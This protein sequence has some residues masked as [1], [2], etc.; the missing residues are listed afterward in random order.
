MLPR[1][2]SKQRLRLHFFVGSVFIMSVMLR[3]L[4]QSYSRVVVRRTEDVHFRERTV[5]FVAMAP[6]DIKTGITFKERTSLDTTSNTDIGHLAP[7]PPLRQQDEFVTGLFNEE[8]GNDVLSSAAKSIPAHEHADS[9]KELVFGADAAD[10]KTTSTLPPSFQEERLLG[11]SVVILANSVTKNTDQWEQYYNLYLKQFKQSPIYLDGEA[12]DNL[13]ARLRPSGQLE[14]VSNVPLVS[15]IMTTWN[16]ETS[17]YAAAMSI[18]QQTWSSIEL[19]I[20]DDASTDGT[21]QV[22]QDISAAHDNVKLIRNTV[23]VGPYV[24]KNIA[25]QKAGGKYITGHDSDDWSHPQ[26]I[27]L[28]MRPILESFGRVR[29]TITNCVRISN[30]LHTTIHR[31]VVD[32]ESE[33]RWSS[34]DGVSHTALVSLL[35]DLQWMND[36]VGSWDSVAFGADGEM[37]HR[38]GT[39]VGSGGLVFVQAVGMFCVA[40]KNSLSQR[41]GGYESPTS[42]RNMYKH[43]YADWHDTVHSRGNAFIPFPPSEVR[44]FSAPVAAVIE[45]IRICTNLEANGLTC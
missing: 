30:E 35:V 17:V 1:V 8:D 9:D 23:N 14:N 45:R 41:G 11:R 31:S 4:A 24:S 25:L 33:F 39:M 3:K 12:T 28:Q 34:L 44:Q 40:L 32:R 37:L 20:V 5:G 15:V 18:L 16:S 7:P 42:V 19:L 6:L 36:K 2:K 10:S 22:L 38:I 43:S 27:E 29:A 21:W 26:R 13:S